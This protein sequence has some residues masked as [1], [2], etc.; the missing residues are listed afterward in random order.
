M[1]SHK[2]D[3]AHMRVL[4][5]ALGHPEHA[6]PSVLI[7]GTNGKGSTAATLASILHAAGYNV[8]LYT[9]PHLVRINE[10]IRINGE[11]IDDELFAATYDHVHH[12]ADRLVAEKKLPW[13]PSFF[14]TVTAIAFECFMRLKVDIAVLE[15]GMGGRLDA[16]NITEPLLSVVTDVGLDHQKFL[17]DTI[18]AIAAEKAGIMR[19]GKPAITLPQHPQAN[20][21][22]G[23]K[24]I[25]TGAV[26]VNATRNVPPV[27][28]G[29]QAL[30]DTSEPGRTRY[31]LSV[32]GEEI[33]IDTALVGRH[34]LRNLALAITAAEELTGL[35]FS[36]TPAQ[37]AEGISQTRWPGRFQ[38]VPGQGNR[39]EIILDVAHNPAG[40]WALRG[41][42][43]ERFLDRPL[44]LVFGAMRDKAIDEIA[45]ILFP[46]ADV[47]VATHTEHNPRSATTA[48][49]RAAGERSGAEIIEVPVVKDAIAKASEAATQRKHLAAPVIVVTG[50]IYIV[51]EAME[52]LGIVP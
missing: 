41:A 25:E 18:A 5:E 45:G 37:I 52:S 7:A 34:Q 24:M 50:S 38:Y 20:Q 35:G 14:E 1:P 17:G 22:L 28:P 31:M 32:L 8:G 40:A 48:E 3:L 13:H 12:V 43:S 26:P 36:I 15:V 39:P 33:L 23:E 21:V 29:S 46:T 4:T 47:V 9:S 27:S 6:V 2:F 49:I 44:Y 51:G 42:L 10:R 30:F 19:A 11:P 16:T